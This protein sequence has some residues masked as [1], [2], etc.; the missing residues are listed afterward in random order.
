MV[1]V[2]GALSYGC[3]TEAKRESDTRRDTATKEA[4][5]ALSAVSPSSKKPQQAA[6]ESTEP[7]LSFTVRIGS[8]ELHLTEGDQLP[9]KGT[10]TD[11]SVS[12]TVDPE[13]V[14]T[15]AGLSFSYPRH[16]AFEAE[17]EDRASQSW[18][19]SGNDVKIMI[20]RFP[21]EL[22]VDSFAKQIAKGFGPNASIS[23]ISIQ[24]GPKEYSGQR[25]RA[26]V[27][28]H[29]FTQDIFPLPPVKE[30]GRFF[31]VQ[32]DASG[33]KPESKPTRALLAKTFRVTE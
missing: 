22:S 11:P 26:T 13:R 32:D 27:A 6:D 33:T 28:T 12:V 3:R 4:A 2:L 30:Q 15:H 25:V 9:A 1:V 17:L 18:T 7:K 29:E 31:V 10:F 8:T 23:P 21:T 24:L 14:F 5:P 19:L 20:F 16:F